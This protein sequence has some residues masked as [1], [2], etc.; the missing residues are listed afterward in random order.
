MIRRDFVPWA[1]SCNSINSRLEKWIIPYNAE[2]NITPKEK[3]CQQLVSLFFLSF[4]SIELI[5]G[6]EPGVV[7]G[8]KND[9]A[10]T[11]LVDAAVEPVALACSTDFF[12]CLFIFSLASLLW[13]KV[14]NVFMALWMSS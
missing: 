4:F 8:T 10:A 14:S 2:R 6:C 5:D 9:E 12:S 11:G 7:R 1:N 3:F 13:S